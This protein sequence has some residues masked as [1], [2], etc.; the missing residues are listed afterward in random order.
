MNE[1]CVRANAELCNKLQCT[2]EDPT[3]EDDDN[4]G[5]IIGLSVGGG[6]VVLGIGVYLFLRMYK[7]SKPLTSNV[8]KLLF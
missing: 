3:E 1:K 6:V 5:L 8:G 7:A 4:M 2:E